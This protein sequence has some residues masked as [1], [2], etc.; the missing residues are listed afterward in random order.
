MTSFANLTKV[1]ILNNVTALVT[2]CLRHEEIGLVL[3]NIRLPVNGITLCGLNIIINGH[4]IPLFFF[5]FFLPGLHKTQVVFLNIFSAIFT[6][7]EATC[8]LLTTNRS[9][10]RV[11]STAKFVRLTLCFV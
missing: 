6:I 2:D 10:T 1:V 11:T 7:Y 8:V 4:I 5:L 3:K 9:V